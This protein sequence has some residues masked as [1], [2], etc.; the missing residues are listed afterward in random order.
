MN[1]HCTTET[2][3]RVQ[4]LG[5]GTY[6][7]IQLEEPNTNSPQLAADV[8]RATQIAVSTK[9]GLPRMHEMDSYNSF[10]MCSY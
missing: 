3:Y 1:R 7:K 10:I 2:S 9:A 6:S 5:R 4:D 8:P